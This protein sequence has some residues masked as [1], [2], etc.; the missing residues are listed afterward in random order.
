MAGCILVVDDHIE[1]AE[2]LAEALGEAGWRAEALDSGARAL[3]RLEAGGVEALVTDLRMDGVGGLELLAASR[4]LDPRRPVIVMTAYG[5]IDTA[6]DSIRQ[7]AYHY[8]TKPF[9][10]EELEIFLRRALEEQDLQKEA[11]R[12][13][14]ALREQQPIDGLVGSSP[15]MREVLELVNRLA[16]VDVPVLIQ[17]ETG[18]GKSLVASA[19]HARS[20]RAKGPFVSINCAA[21]PEALLESELFGHAK[22][23]FTGASSD[24]PGLFAEA[25]AGTLLLDE[26]GDLPLAIQAKLLHVLERATVR[27]VGSN[28]ERKVDVRILAATHRD[29]HDMAQRQQ[30]RE[31]LLYRLDVVT[32]EIPA[33]KHRKEDILPLVEHFLEIY[34]GRFTQS[35][36]EGFTPAA[37]ARFLDYPWPGNIRE[38]SHVVQRMVVLGRRVQADVDEL[39][40]AMRFDSGNPMDVFTHVLPA[41]ELQHRYAQ[42]ALERCGGLKN[43]TATSLDIDIKTLNRWLQDY[44]NPDP[45]STPQEQE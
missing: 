10:P 24:R 9:Q 6:V 17:G 45:Q 36:V 8:L 2:M 29:L 21:L 44:S 5:A 42:W 3:E 40:Q 13:R 15:A 35:P 32:I 28:R 23:A 43:R 1:M 4:R 18:T 41:R 12:L 20:S 19:I 7:G 16:M 39:P 11:Q 31:D 25:E 26:I 34:R 27:P 38:L 33:L 30:F 22:G 37:L 14:K